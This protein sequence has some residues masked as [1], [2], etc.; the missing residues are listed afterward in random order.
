MIRFQQV[1]TDYFKGEWNLYFQRKCPPSFTAQEFAALLKQLTDDTSGKTP[2]LIAAD[3]NVWSTSR[4][5][6][7][8][9]GTND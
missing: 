7:N 9:K 5:S 4:G 1:V 8:T 3:F 2:F 6:R